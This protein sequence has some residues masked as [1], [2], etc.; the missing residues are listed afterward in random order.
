M[1]RGKGI[2][3]NSLYFHFY[4]IQEMQKPTTLKKGDK[5]AI[6][7]TARKATK[8]ELQAGIALA[9]SWGL[10]VIIGKSIGAEDHQFGGN[11]KLRAEDFQTQLDN[12][13][14]KAIWCARGGYGTIRIIDK[15]DF[16]QFQKNPKW[17]I[18]YS[19]VT[20]LHSHIHNLGI[21]TLH[22]QMPVDIENKSKAAQESIR[23]VLFDED[24]SIN[25]S[26]SNRLN[27]KGTAEGILVGGNL[28]MLY[29]MCGSPT[30]IDTKDKILFIEDLDEYLYH[31][32]RM[33]QNLKRNGY[34]DSIK[35]LL[36]GGM[37]EMND[38]AIPFGY[39]AQEIVSH[40]INDKNIP[41]IF[42][43]PA[44]HIKNNLALPLGRKVQVG[45]RE[46][47]FTMW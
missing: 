8:E 10:E 11:D 33:M 46:D 18:G 37:T 17:I 22:A 23:K 45:L 38:N 31:V 36:V 14:I 2:F 6:V 3:Q 35:A 16:S 25:F 4:K 5:I 29:S 1:S 30:A 7:T 19:D 42:D 43:F 13:E 12:P 21:Q 40:Y 39:T 34:F 20:V 15:L 44:G 32:D 27:R 24:Y 28:S 47:Y 41:L 26:T 9:K